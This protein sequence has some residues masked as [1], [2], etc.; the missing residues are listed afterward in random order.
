MRNTD[1]RLVTEVKAVFDEVDRA[2]AAQPDQTPPWENIQAFVK[3]SRNRRR[4]RVAL[5]AGAAAMAVVTLFVLQGKLFQV[6]NQGQP[7]PAAPSFEEWDKTQGSL[8]DDD[9]WLSDLREF[10]AY[11][12]VASPDA[13]GEPLQTPGKN[14]KVLFASDIGEYRVAVVTADWES[15]DG[16]QMAEFVG[17]RGAAAEDMEPGE[18][19]GSIEEMGSLQQGLVYPEML[20]DGSD[21][22]PNSA[23]VY[24]LATGDVPTVQVQRPPTIDAQ[25][26]VTQHTSLLEFDGGAA[27][28]AFDQTGHYAVVIPSILR[29]G[30][31]YALSDGYQDFTIGSVD[32]VD[33]PPVNV[34]SVRGDQS[35]VA[36]IVNTMA[37]YTW[38]AVRQT[39]DQ[40]EWQLLLA[41]PGGLTATGPNRVVVGV[42]TLPGGAR[43][44]SAGQ[45]EADTSN[46]GSAGLS[47]LDTARILPAGDPDDVSIAWRLGEGG[48]KAK[49]TAAVGPAGTESVEWS[50]KNG[51]TIEGQAVDTLATIDR[52]DITSVRFLDG[53]GQELGSQK[54]LAPAEQ[55]DQEFGEQTLE[56]PDVMG[57]WQLP[58]IEDGLAGF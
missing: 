46:D 49:R 45:V 29:S 15:N 9:D 41:E 40:G 37:L 25:G 56:S 7:Q 33:A 11:S 21:V 51:G 23:A 35:R 38:Y 28:A 55:P 8:R 19:G 48:A 27:T 39:P 34:E 42:L 24:V 50:T 10:A 58:E 2:L 16:T 3:R 43:V 47:W 20:P 6:S 4:R 5:V 52:T 30:E 57:Y 53:Q 14:V 26:K 13:T 32:A 12:D 36:E 54:V 22:D 31:E 1:D 17:P 18:G 44:V